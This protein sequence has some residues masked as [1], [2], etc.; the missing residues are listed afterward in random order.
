MTTDSR[1]LLEQYRTL[2]EVSESILL[3]RNIPDLIADLGERLP[4]VLKFDFISLFAF[5][6]TRRCSRLL[7]LVTPI[8]HDIPPGFEQPLEGTISGEIFRAQQ[9]I[10]IHD[11]SSETRFPESIA[12]LRKYE[13][14]SACYVPLTSAVRKI[15]TLGIGVR[16]RNAYSQADRDFLEVVGRQI[17]SAIDNA[18]HYEEVTRYQRDLQNERDHL[19]LMLDISN[20][21]VSKRRL[22]ELFSTISGSLRSM[23][24]QEYSSLSLFDE[25]S[26]RLIIHS[27]DFP[28]GKGYVKEGMEIT[29]DGSWSGRAFKERRPVRL[30]GPDM[31]R[32]PS[33]AAQAIVAEGL[34]SG[35]SVPLIAHGLVLGTLAVAGTREDGFTEAD[36]KLLVEV[37]QQV[38]MAVENALAFKQIEEL[39]NRLAE[40]KLYLED[41]IRNE[42]NVEEIIGDSTALRDVLNEVRTVAPTDSTVLILGETGTGKEMIARAIHNLSPRGGRTFVKMNCAAIPTGLLESE[43]F[44]HERGAFTGAIAQKI[45]RFE[46]AHKGTL[47]LDEIGDISAEL[48]PKLLRVLQEGE[49]E[50]LGSTRTIKCDVRLV[51]ATNRDLREMVENRAFRSDLYYRLNVFP[52]RVPPLRDRRD[53]IPLLLRFFAQKFAVLMKRQIETIPQEAM[54]V[55]VAYDWPGNVRELQNFVE[56]AVILTRGTSLQLPVSELNLPAPEPPPSS[57]AGNAPVTL[58][59]AERDHIFKT[60]NETNWI[61]GGPNGAAARLGMKR[62]TLQSR[63][64]KLGIRRD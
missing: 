13:M 37:A 4:K 15:G 49:F 21:L 32:F 47:F 44:G 6:E 34:K 10:I 43:L 24:R 59:S 58:E 40:E 25:E 42:R 50:R 60:L 22:I 11:T 48:Q 36:E 56:R 57:E 19:R 64:K 39:K 29:V 33:V 38:A 12:V 9:S 16:E 45:G 31:E 23:M 1:W 20:V 2:L 30:H 3:H 52:I 17:A 27:L 41:E 8:P 5:D 54:E 61:I 62:T 53:D 55:C 28:S 7:L 14:G 26:Q 51:A 35:C 46:L 63:M 18:L